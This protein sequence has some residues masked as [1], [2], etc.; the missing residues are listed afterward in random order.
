MLIAVD[1]GNTNVT[2]GIFDGEKRK[3]MWRTATGVHRMADEYAS[4][5][6]N[7]FKISDLNP[8]DVKQAVLCS[9]VPPLVTTFEDIFKRYFKT[10]ALVI[11]A[12]VKTGIKIC[13]DNPREVGADR[14]VNAVGAYKLY[15]GPSI[16]I[17]MGTATT[18]DTVSKDGDYIGG[19]ISPGIA[20]AM[21]ALFNRT[22]AL[23]RV[24]LTLPKKAI[25]TNTIAAMQ[26]GI[27][28]GYIGLIDGVVSRIQDELGT[29][30]KVIAT[31]GYSSLIAKGTKSIDIVDHDLTL[32]GLRLLYELNKGQ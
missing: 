3:A 18:F 32:I 17:D 21:D 22:A 29:K 13:M 4:F 28:F 10:S 2:I 25:G 19:A 23:P 12:G 1:I 8:A 5:M 27:V 14:I 31:G 20:I 9:V 16:V 7:M 6:F 26:S 24:E 30:A 11:E 15:G